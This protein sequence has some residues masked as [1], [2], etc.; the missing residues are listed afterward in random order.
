MTRERWAEVRR[1]FNQAVRYADIT[2]RDAYLDGACQGDEDL[3]REIDSLL[4][5]LDKAGPF[6][7]IYS[8]LGDRMLSHYNVLDRIGEGGMGIVYRAID[9]RL[10]RL[11]ALKVLHSWM[12]TD[13]SKRELLFRE[14]Q[15]ASALKNHPNVVTIHDV[16]EDNGVT[17]IVMEYVE[18]K[19][20]NEMING[21]PIDEALDY[22]LQIA[23]AL[24]AAH[25]TG[26]L[27]GDFKPRNVM[28]TNDGR[29]KLLDFGLARVLAHV[30]EEAT[31]Q[32]EPLGTLSYMAPE[33][34]KSSNFQSFDPRSEVFSFGLVFYE[35]LVGKHPFISRERSL[36]QDAITTD[37]LTKEVA[38]S[39]AELIFHCIQ[40]NP[41]HRFPSMKEV[42]TELAS[43]INRANSQ[44]QFFSFAQRVAE[45]FIPELIKKRTV[46]G[47]LYLYGMDYA[48]KVLI[49][50][51]FD[52][53]FLV[54]AQFQE[55]ILLGAAFQKANILGADFTGADLTL[56][57]FTGSDW[58]NAFGLTETQLAQARKETLLECPG[59]I[60]ELRRHM[61][62]FYA[63][64][65]SL[66]EELWM[67]H[68]DK[69]TKTWQEYLRPGGLRDVV[70]SWRKDSA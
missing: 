25:S 46:V 18:G 61:D 8:S 9:T 15:C 43:R 50:V 14:A 65:D 63:T 28:V 52:R 55:S 54:D 37:L 7:S 21:L 56:A 45:G 36:P 38:K 40:E 26:I 20:L 17:F 69:L 27:H 34:L 35:M 3:R 24:S 53:T 47:P 16:A 70:A 11:V 13:P 64:P 31:S 33:Q 10:R 62:G 48:S 49:N 1:I 4:C 57:E 58:F 22:A 41:E 68:G 44:R 6:L 29:V 30:E 12:M 32:G 5:Q 60:A 19:T 39:M 23:N 67:T 59:G 51:S 2:A 42:H 66:S